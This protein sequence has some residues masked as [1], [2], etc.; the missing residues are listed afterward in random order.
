[1][2][3][4]RTYGLITLV[5]ISLAGC[6]IK[7]PVPS[8]GDL[9]RIRERT[10]EAHISAAQAYEN[11]GDT[12]AAIEEWRVVSALE[13]DS[14]EISARIRE[15]EASAAASS[16][17]LLQ[18]ARGEKARGSLRSARNLTLAALAFDPDS[19]AA[20]KLLRSIEAEQ[21][22][23]SLATEPLEPAPSK[24]ESKYYSNLVSEGATD[25]T[26][27]PSSAGPNLAEKAYR[28]GLALFGKDKGKAVRAFDEALKYDPD[29]RKARTYRDTLRRLGFR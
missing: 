7:V 26:S 25:D 16:V 10:L 6:A 17:R 9:D 24:P 3:G 4:A 18:Q 20:Q 22:Q 12:W 23:H 11:K 5:G 29:H 14:R 27:E 19:G 28:R 2:M 8:F 15:L 13:P 1:M 21:S